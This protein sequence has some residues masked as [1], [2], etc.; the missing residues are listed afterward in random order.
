M[1]MEKVN[2]IEIQSQNTAIIE[3]VGDNGIRMKIKINPDPNLHLFEIDNLIEDAWENHIKKYSRALWSTLDPLYPQTMQHLNREAKNNPIVFMTRRDGPTAW[4][5]SVDWLERYGIEDPMVYC[6]KPGEEK[7][8]VCKK[9]GIKFIID[10]SHR[11]AP[12]LM[13]KGVSV[14]MPR[15]KYNARYLNNNAGYIKSQPSW[16]GNLYEAKGRN[17]LAQLLRELRSLSDLLPSKLGFRRE[18]IPPPRL[19]LGPFLLPLRFYKRK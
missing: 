17:E 19:G 10:D 16:M 7:G 13:M 18:L 8:D 1:P 11:Y 4:K 12:E 14:I 5:E 3:K 15:Y 9:M 6:I 2:M